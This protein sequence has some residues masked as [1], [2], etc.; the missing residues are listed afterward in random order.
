MAVNNYIRNKC[1]YNLNKLD[2][3]I[4]LYEFTNPILDYITDEN[5]TNATSKENKGNCYEIYCDSVQ[6]TS[7]SSN[8]NRFYFD[9]TLTV[10]INE[11]ESE[12][13]YKLIDK[14]IK[15]SWM[16]LFKNVEGDIFVMNGEYPIMVTYQYV[17]NDEKTPNTLTITF[18]VLQNVPT[19]NYRASVNVSEVWRSK[20]C[21]YVLSRIESLKMIDK[22]RCDI[23][24][25]TDY[26][27][28]I[29]K[30]EGAFKDIEFNPTSMSFIDSFDGNEYTQT[31]SFTI[32]FNSYIYFFHYNLL[33][34]L[35]NNYYAL[36]S[37]TNGN[38]I[39]SG[40]KKG[41]FP[42]YAINA[43][44]DNT[45]NI[46]L[47]NKSNSHSTIAASA[48]T[49]S[50]VEYKEY[51]KLLG[52]CIDNYYTYTLLQELNT[53]NYYCLKGYE[54]EYADYNIVGTYDKFDTTYGFKLIDYRYD[55]F[56]E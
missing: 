28:I 1:Q 53:E 2:N 6:Y 13:Y 11:A 17:I 4:Y 39:F 12:L 37:T 55:C 19:I 42:S 41:L 56:N 54:D 14:I 22:K 10:T 24:V 29:Q 44:E 23:D 7:N 50:I 51:V 25:E 18:K 46:T 21:S 48:Y 38:H 3:Y 31:L 15:G 52:D 33:E 26:L 40:Y 45:I 36:I 35:D 32:P 49:L 30:G 47:I 20:P 34:Y 9:N 27:H 5:E 43:N 8:D 16:V